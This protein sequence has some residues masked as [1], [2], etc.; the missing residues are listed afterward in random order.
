MTAEKELVWEFSGTG[1]TRRPTATRTT[2]ARS[3]PGTPN[4]RAVVPPPHVRTFYKGGEAIEQF[5]IGQ[6]PPRAAVNAG[7]GLT[8]RP[9]RHWTAT[10]SRAA[11]SASDWLPATSYSSTAR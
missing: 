5:T 11:W 1:S 4:E 6:S 10:A 7:G 3:S 2:T 9:R 8:P